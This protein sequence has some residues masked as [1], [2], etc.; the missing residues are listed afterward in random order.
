MTHRIG[1]DQ[2]S[3]LERVEMEQ[4]VRTGAGSQ[5]WS[6]GS[7]A[8][9]PGAI[10]RRAHFSSISGRMVSACCGYHHFWIA[11]NCGCRQLWIPPSGSPFNNAADS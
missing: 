2:V 7:E 6:Q 10:R 4:S 8:A 11:A 1:S 3:E 5:N 9:V